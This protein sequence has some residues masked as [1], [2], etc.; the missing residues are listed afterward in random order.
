MM[1]YHYF[2]LTMSGKAGKAGNTPKMDKHQVYF[3][4]SYVAWRHLLGMSNMLQTPVVAIGHLQ[5]MPW[6]CSEAIFSQ[7]SQ[8]LENPALV[9][10]ICS[11]F[12]QVAH[13]WFHFYVWLIQ[14]TTHQ[15]TPA[16]IFPGDF[17]Y[18]LHRDMTTSDHP[19][20]KFLA[21]VDFLPKLSGLDKLGIIHCC[22]SL[23]SCVF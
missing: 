2:S 15:I 22:G 23:G 11:V 1:V 9:G 13:D 4:V 14:N 10:F 7:S 8:L 17:L 19:L 20:H 3:H 16:Q 12:L 18:F 5:Y 21:P 6:D